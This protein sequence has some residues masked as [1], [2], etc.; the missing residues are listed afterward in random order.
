MHPNKSIFN[1]QIYMTQKI[2]TLLVLVTTLISCNSE[3]EKGYDIIKND[4]RAPAYP[5]ITIDP[6]TS[7]WA[8]TDNLYDDN[9]RHWTGKEFPLIGAIKVDNKIYRFMGIEKMEFAPVLETSEQGEWYGKYTMT[10]PSDNWMQ[11]D[12]ND[13]SWKEGK[14]A[15]G[16]M[17][18]EKTAKTSWET[19]YIWVRRIFNLE[20]D[21]NKKNKDIYLEYSH[22]DDVIIYINGIEVVNIG[23]KAKKNQR[24][25]LPENVLSTLKKGENIIAGFCHNRRGGALLDFGLQVEKDEPRY[26]DEAAKQKSV[27]VQATQTH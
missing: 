6:Y 22:D 5:L 20:E 13:K 17:A 8:F 21:L 18:S 9:I 2:L 24:V 7:G 23:D 1:I 16:T 4:L 19:E 3:K 25:K 12:F 26:F 11:K 14:A 10:K 15:F 27:D